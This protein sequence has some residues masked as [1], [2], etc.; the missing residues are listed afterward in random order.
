F[1]PQHPRHVFVQFDAPASLAE[2]VQQALRTR[3]DTRGHFSKGRCA[4]PTLGHDTG[5][6]DP[7][8]HIRRTDHD[9]RGAEYGCQLL[10]VIDAIWQRQDT[11]IAPDQRLCRDNRRGVIVHLDRKEPRLLWPRLRRIADGAAWHGEG[12]VERTFDPQA[13]LLD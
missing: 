8:F 9:P 5:L 3:G 2:D 10:T 13:M 6:L 11:G 4:W 7:A 1:F 12:T